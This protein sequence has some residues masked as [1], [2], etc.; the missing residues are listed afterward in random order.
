[1]IMVRPVDHR[2]G[3]T[4]ANS[5]VFHAE[6]GRLLV[7]LPAPDDL[8]EMRALGAIVCREPSRHSRTISR[9]SIGAA[10]SPLPISMPPPFGDVR[11]SIYRPKRSQPAG[12]KRVTFSLDL[13]LFRP[14]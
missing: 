1:M 9:S 12:A 6:D 7:A 8:I 13:L 2:A 5:G 10:S 3:S 14:T 4:P 11:H